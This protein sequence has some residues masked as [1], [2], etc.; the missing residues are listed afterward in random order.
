MGAQ[1][2]IPI[3]VSPLHVIP[4]V[5]NAVDGF[6]KIYDLQEGQ[7]IFETPAAMLEAL[8]VFNLTQTSAYDFFKSLGVQEKFVKKMVDGASRCNYNQPGTMNSF[9]D[10]ISLA[11]V[12]VAGHV[13]GLANGT[14]AISRGLLRSASRVHL[15]EHVVKVASHGTGYLVQTTQRSEQFDGVILA[16]PLELAAIQLPAEAKRGIGVSWQ[17]V[18]ELVAAPVLVPAKREAT[19]ALDS[20]L[21]SFMVRCAKLLRASPMSPGRLLAQCT[22]ELGESPTSSKFAKQYQVPPEFPD[23]LKDFTREVLRSQPENI[24]EFAAKYFECLASGLP[25]DAGQ[26]TAAEEL[27]MSL[28]EVE[29]I[30]HDLFKKYDKDGSQFL[31]PAEF[32]SLMEDLQ[33]RLDFPKDEILLFLAEADMNADGMIEYE[34]F[35]PLALQIIQ[36]MYAKKRL[37]Q[38]ISDVDLQAEELLVHGMSRE[39]LTSL[40]GSMFERMDEDRSG[41]LNKQEFVT[42]LTSMELG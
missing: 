12:G 34:E 41:Q 11:G 7:K 1:A 13:F 31:D 26:A 9:A 42:A 14:Q 35:I 29:G 2:S 10:L 28:D 6:D 37:E 18:A 30:I 8:G 20:R 16:T 4:A 33:Q 32:K 21:C 15:G 36:G 3:W 38:H 39:E 5:G 40:V 22:V 24:H 23:I 27:D 25:V 17:P 19:L